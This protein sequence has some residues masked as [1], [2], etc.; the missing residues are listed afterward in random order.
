MTW[1]SRCYRWRESAAIVLLAV[2]D[3]RALSVEDPPPTPRTPREP[4]TPSLAPHVCAR[5]H[6]S[7]I[8]AQAAGSLVNIA[9]N[10]SI[11]HKT[12]EPGEAKHAI[13]DQAGLP[14]PQRASACR[15]FHVFPSIG[16]SRSAIEHSASER[17]LPPIQVIDVN[18]DVTERLVAQ[19]SRHLFSEV[20]ASRPD[21]LQPIGAG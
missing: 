15:L 1:A 13:N 20:L 4:P 17:S 11:E 7:M 10:I 5:A 12:R 3:A 21:Q 6:L 9:L 19:R 8:T 16:P 2:G 18:E 14:G